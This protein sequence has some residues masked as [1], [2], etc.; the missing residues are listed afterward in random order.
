MCLRNTDW[1]KGALHTGKTTAR[2]RLHQDLEQATLMFGCLWWAG[3]KIDWE[4]AWGSC[5]G[6]GWW[7][8]VMGDWWWWWVISDDDRWL[9]MVMGDG[10]E[11]WW[12]M[13]LNP[14]P[15]VLPI[16]FLWSN[17]FLRWVRNPCHL[18]GNSI[19]LMQK[20]PKCSKESL[21]CFWVLT[22]C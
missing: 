13:M 2:F 9:V 4:E 22:L 12:W 7:W 3:V 14:E 1:V 11:W 5:P 17:S 10:D 18:S 16:S 20:H 15:Y 6:D 19:A 21:F 8:W